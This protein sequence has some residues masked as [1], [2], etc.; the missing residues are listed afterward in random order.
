MKKRLLLSLFVVLLSCISAAAQQSKPQPLTFWYEYVINPGKED[1][2]MDLV[3]TVG[4]P[5]RD[6]F[7]ADGVINAWG[8]EV[9]LLRQPGG[10]THVIW[11]EV[12]DW[13]GI[14]K[15]D[16]AMRAQIAKLSG[17]DESKTPA[18]KKAQKSA[19][20]MDRLREDADMS[21]THD[22]LT[23][24]LVINETSAST[25]GVMP[26]TRYNYVKARPGKASD[27][28]K[29]WEKYNKPVLDKL[30]ADGTVLAYGLSVEEV[31]TDGEFTHF[32]WIETK[33][34]ASLEKYR[35]AFTADREH[36]SEEERNSLNDPFLSLIDPDASRS[37]VKRSIVFHVPAAK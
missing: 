25:A 23:R 29:A 10:A 37:E 36:R 31:R 13:S 22:Y 21:K 35:N 28:R 19:T 3:K 24:D 1:D 8:V 4:Q 15:I 14:E 34:L 27:Y 2:F 9:P 16:A 18:T 33:D 26:Y 30:I 7:M 32:T 20:V 5:V 17:G 12:S 11:Y 6:K